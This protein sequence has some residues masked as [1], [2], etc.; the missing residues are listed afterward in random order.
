MRT[1]PGFFAVDRRT[2]A[3]LLAQR[4]DSIGER[5]VCL[6]MAARHASDIKDAANAICQLEKLGDFFAIECVASLAGLPDASRFALR[7]LERNGQIGLVENV[8]FSTQDAS[9]LKYAATILIT[10]GRVE[11]LLQRTETTPH[12]AEILRGVAEVLA[13]SVQAALGKSDGREL[14]LIAKSKLAGLLSSKPRNG[15]DSEILRVQSAIEKNDFP[16]L[17]A[18]AEEVKEEFLQHAGKK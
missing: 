11:E 14:A 12:H 10:S 16:S 17:V 18:I 6:K 9:V 4:K 2:A 15:L 13:E 7:V 8:V 1:V 3:F 5:I